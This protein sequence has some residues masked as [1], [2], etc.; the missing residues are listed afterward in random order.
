MSL[1][2]PW[3]E[4]ASFVSSGDV[5]P[6][7]QED[8]VSGDRETDSNLSDPNLQAAQSRKEHLS[9]LYAL[10]TGSKHLAGCVGWPALHAVSRFYA[11]PSSA[12]CCAGRIKFSSVIVFQVNS[13]SPSC[14]PVF[15]SQTNERWLLDGRNTSCER[16]SLRPKSHAL[17]N[18]QKSWMRFVVG[19]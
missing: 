2:S 12:C 13:A 8:S 5:Q 7:R 19:S 15:A 9:G 16:A 17:C 11:G 6:E 18:Q 14:V 10:N 1:H 3:L 4:A